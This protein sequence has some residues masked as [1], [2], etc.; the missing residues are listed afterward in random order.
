VARRTAWPSWRQG[1]TRSALAGPHAPALERYRSIEARYGRIARDEHIF[2]MHVHVA[3]PRTSIAAIINACA[4]TCRTCSRCPRARPSSRARTPASLVPHHHVAALAELGHPAA[5]R[6]DAEFSAYVDTLLD[7]GVMADPWNLY[8][9]MRPHPKY[10]TIEFRVTDVCP[11]VADAAAIAALAR[12]LVH[13]IVNGTLPR[14]AAPSRR[15]LEQELLRVNEWRVAR[16]GLGGDHRHAP[17]AR[18]RAGAL[19]IRR[20]LDR[21]RPQRRRTRRQRRALAQ[22]ETMLER[23]NA[24]D[25]MR[26]ALRESGTLRRWCGGSWTRAWSGRDSTA[27]PR[28]AGGQPVTA[29]GTGLRVAARSRPPTTSSWGR[30]CCATCRSCCR[31]RPGAALR[32]DRARRR[33]GAARRAR[34]TR[35]VPP[36]GRRAAHVR[37][38]RG[39]ARR[40]RAGPR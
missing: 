35:C 15:N 17:W 36:A 22:V 3:C 40:G 7:A 8:W 26:R 27:A 6:D 29:G 20:L 23:G 24:A 14:T 10:P 11:S 5:L 16:D 30:R 33:G 34:A 39:A 19:P 38:R 25:R 1:C 28:T 2:G 4:T 13:A 12:A 31:P 18:A 9:S 37:G 32:R 21:R